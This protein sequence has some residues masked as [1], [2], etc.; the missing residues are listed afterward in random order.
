[1]TTKE[2]SGLFVAEGRE[3][4]RERL[5]LDHTWSIDCREKLVPEQRVRRIPPPRTSALA[6]T[7]GAS[8]FAVSPPRAKS[9]E[10]WAVREHQNQK[11]AYDHG[12]LTLLI[13]LAG[14]YQ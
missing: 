12:A 4:I 5:H 1:M 7:S 10:S 3:E 14:S 6:R 9:Y 8:G 2:M 13:L 11:C